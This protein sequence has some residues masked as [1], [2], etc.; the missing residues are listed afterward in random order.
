MI[1]RS[2]A[3]KGSPH[4]GS[5][6]AS[7]EPPPPEPTPPGPAEVGEPETESVRPVPLASVLT[8]SPEPQR[9]ATQRFSVRNLGP[10]LLVRAAHPRQAFLTAAGLTAAA[11]LAGRTT[12][13]LGLVFATVLVG[14]AILGWHNDLVDRRRDLAHGA[15]GKPVAQDRLEPGTVWFSL[16]CA[17]L[18]VIPLSISNGVTAGS[19]YLLSLAAGLLANVVLR[20]GWLSWLPWATSYALFPAFLSYGG[21]GGA[22]TGNPPEISITV[23]AGLL[24]VGVHFLRALPGLVADNEDGYRHLPLRIALRTGATRLLVLS[25]LWTALVLV[26]LVVAGNAVGLAQ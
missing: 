6:D 5:D 20:K 21:W 8:T 15:A 11:A 14:Q 3:K 17:V 24:G 18:L 26:G 4:T 7:P 12:R 9:R 2:R 22:A 19:A 13:E 10:V 1:R 25:S 16:A 23:L